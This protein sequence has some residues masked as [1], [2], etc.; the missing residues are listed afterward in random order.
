ME[1]LAG[2]CSCET[3]A[4]PNMDPLS[5]EDV[6]KSI[7]RILRNRLSKTKIENI[8][9]DEL[10]G[11]LLTY[12]QELEYQN[13][14]LKRVHKD[15]EQNLNRM[16]S[17]VAL[18][19]SAFTTED[20]FLQ[21]ILQ[22]AVK[23]IGCKQGCL[24][25]YDL[26]K[27]NLSVKNIVTT[28]NAQVPTP[29]RS[30][31]QNLMQEKTPVITDKNELFLPIFYEEKLY[32][33][34]I[35]EGRTAS[36]DEMSI[37]QLTLLMNSTFRILEK[38]KAEHLKETYY[39]ALRDMHQPVLITDRS[40][41][42]QEANPALLAMYGY[43]EEE[44]IGQN[45]RVLNPGIETYKNLG[46]S[47]TYYRE[48]FQTLW[49]DIL[50]PQKGTWNGILI[51]RKKNGTLVWAQTYIAAIRDDQGVIRSFI[52]LPVDISPLKESEFR[53]KTE[54]YRTIARLAELRDNE[55]GNHMR[56]VGIYSRLLSK[57][58]GMPDKFCEEMELFAP[59]HD[60]GKVGISDTIL[61]A[62]RP[63]TP[64]EYEEIKTHTLL[65]FNIV[66]DKEE[67]KTAAEIILHHHE[68]FDGKGY[69]HGLKGEQI[70][71]SARITTTADV[72]DALRSKRPY[73]PEWSHEEALKE[74]TKN[75]GTIFDPR[76]V[77]V[78]LQLNQQFDEVYRNLKD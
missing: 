74:I 61:L 47:E 60:I 17:F 36:Y 20:E 49:K 23:L 33:L 19:Q 13:K 76:L 64:E 63:L 44:V 15:S 50:D 59:M 14:E 12:C 53:S 78:F 70:P 18:L 39:R 35:L 32:G 31:L 68:R 48:L 40:G 52:G 62:K 4:F 30:Q 27:E 5:K 2:K 11:T 16:R 69:P 75:S 1:H 41:V 3:V 10:L 29:S 38:R 37:L 9:P 46:F 57:T 7:K 24:Y 45:P 77:Q 56:R 8:S 65:G 22:E 51:N 67:L 21:I 26:T 43:S 71:L 6:Q 34:L 66:R 55:T 42:I 58:L 72:Y 73:K 54:L 28:L 25:Q